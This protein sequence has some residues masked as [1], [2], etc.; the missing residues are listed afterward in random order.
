M[1]DRE[2]RGMMIFVANVQALRDLLKAT[3]SDYELAPDTY[4]VGGCVR[5]DVM[6][7]PIKDLDM[8]VEELGGAKKL[9]WYLYRLFPKYCTRPHELGAGYPIWQIRFKSDVDWNDQF[10][11]VGGIELQIADTQKESYPDSLSRARITNFGSLNEDC[12]RRDFTSNMLYRNILSD[13]VLDPSGSGLSD[14]QKGMLRTHP[15]VSAE[16]IFNDDPLRMLRMLRFSLRFGWSIHPETIEAAKKCSSRLKILSAERVRDEWLKLIEQKTF[17]M[18]WR[19]YKNF[20]FLEILWPEFLPMIGCEQDSTYHSEGDVWIHTLMV[21][22]FAQS[23]TLQQLTALLHDI[24]KPPTRS[25]VG[26]R[27]KFLNHETQSVELAEI[28]LKKWKFPS[29]LTR[30]VLKLIALHL[31]GGDVEKW[32]SLKPARKFLRDAGAL[33][34]ELLS[35][36]EA[37]SRASLGPDFKPR[38]SH[39]PLLRAKLAEAEKIA[40][41]SRS[42][43]SGH[44]IMSVLKI[45]P[46]REIKTI[47]NALLELEDSLAEKGETLSKERAL[48]WICQ[49]FDIQKLNLKI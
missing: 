23:K 21:M 26:E 15:G 44:E 31:R 17:S 13:R 35:F 34:D 30:E 28:F 32:G 12:E 43:L 39:I 47:Q 20:G 2:K 40:T 22:D 42:V 19:D 4:F 9:C 29:L 8:V 38:L 6:G 3:L 25:V 48:E 5:D 11:S 7:L 1:A 10:F 16:K 46:S 24:G 18:A 27:V 49:D 37:D 41:H 14:I 36:I 45:S 33:K